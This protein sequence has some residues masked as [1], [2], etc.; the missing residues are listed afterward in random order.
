MCPATWHNSH[1]SQNPPR[2]TTLTES[3]TWQ[4]NIVLCAMEGADQSA[5]WDLSLLNPTNRAA[6]ARVLSNI[7]LAC[8]GGGTQACL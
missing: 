7:R 1:G 2:G 3:A 8:N 4:A 6:A 5:G